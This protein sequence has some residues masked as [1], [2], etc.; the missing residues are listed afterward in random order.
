MILQRT[1]DECMHEG[2]GALRRKLASQ[3]TEYLGT[4]GAVL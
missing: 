4:E 1:A 3:E 2:E